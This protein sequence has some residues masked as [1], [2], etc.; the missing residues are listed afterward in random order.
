MRRLP[1]N[2]RGEWSRMKRPDRVKWSVLMDAD[3]ER[4]AVE[5]ELDFGDALAELKRLDPAGWEAWYDGR[6]EQT[7][8]EM[9]PLIQERV[10][11]LGGLS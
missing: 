5:F 8:G 3:D 11:A 2:R 4:R 9:L 6:P 1:V 10:R 7:C